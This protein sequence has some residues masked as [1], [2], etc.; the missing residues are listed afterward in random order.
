M[1]TLQNFIVVHALINIR[2]GQH[3]STVCSFQTLPLDPI[4]LWQ[5]Q[6]L[7]TPKIKTYRFTCK[8]RNRKKNLSVLY[9]D[10]KIILNII[11]YNP[12]QDRQFTYNVIE[13]FSRITVAMEK[14]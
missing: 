3:L 7:F 11:K 5:L 4:R 13:E 8:Y 12:E 6:F 10:E 1:G 2:T 14:Q 9:L